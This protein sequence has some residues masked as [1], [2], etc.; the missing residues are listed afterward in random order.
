MRARGA[1]AKSC[2]MSCPWL[3]SP[4]RKQKLGLTE[5]PARLN[6]SN[7]SRGS[8]GFECALPMLFFVCERKAY[9]RDVVQSE[10]VA[11]AGVAR[12]GRDGGHWMPI[13]PAGIGAQAGE[14]PGDGGLLGPEVPR[15][16]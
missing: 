7:P 6:R 5:T 3:S 16:F 8:N 15:A 4:G 14:P 9:G 2:P 10:V 1:T 12:R 11:S 13:R